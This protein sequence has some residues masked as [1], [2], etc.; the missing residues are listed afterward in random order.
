MKSLS[1][2]GYKVRVYNDGEVRIFADKKSIRD[3]NVL[4]IARYLHDEG[5]I[6]DDSEE[7]CINII[8]S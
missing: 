6:R 2:K 1:V 3:E 8:E 7:V 5:F 4:V